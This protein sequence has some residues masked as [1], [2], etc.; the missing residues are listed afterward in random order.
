MMTVVPAV[1]PFIKCQAEGLPQV[2]SV[3]PHVRQE[4]GLVPSCL[5]R[6]LGTE[7]GQDLA[8]VTQTMDDTA[9]T[10]VLCV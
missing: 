10:R 1:A 4:P 6:M 7:R 9:E 3:H 5:M 8:K 2:P